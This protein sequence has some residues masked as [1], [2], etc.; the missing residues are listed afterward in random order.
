MCIW[1]LDDVKG[2]IIVFFFI[3]FKV[4]EY[5]V[6]YFGLVVDV[7]LVVLDVMSMMNY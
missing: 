2:K 4:C 1:L 6:L 3:M 7:F 5:I